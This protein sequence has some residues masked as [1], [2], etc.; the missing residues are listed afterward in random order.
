MDI[1]IPDNWLKEYLKTKATPKEIAKDL[2]LCGP[3]VERVNQTPYGP[4][5]SIEVTTNRIDTACVYGIAREASAILPRFGIKASLKPIT[6]SNFNLVQKVNYLNVD[7]DENLCPR[8]TAILIRNVKIGPSPKWMQDRLY[9]VGERPINNIVDIS[10]YLMHESGQPMHT[11]DYD[12]IGKTSSEGRK[13]AKMILR[14]SKKGE[15]VITLDNQTRVLPG[16]DIVIEDGA[17]RLIDLCGIMGGEL[18]AIDDK[19][20]N[21]LLFVQTYNPFYIR[22]TS[23]K[24]A[25]RTAAAVIFEKATDPELVLIGL[26]RGID[27]F[28][29]LTKGKPEK[30]ILDLYFK[31]YH[32]KYIKTNKKFIEERLGIPLSQKEI[33]KTLSSLGFEIK[34]KGENYEIKIPSYRANDVEIPEDIVEEV[35]RIY[36]YHNLKSELM[37]GGL[38]NIL[39]KS[40]FDFESKVK[41]IIK[42][43]GGVEIYTSS[44]V[45]ES[46]VNKDALKLK[47]PLGPES[48]YLRTSLMPS[49]I[50]AADENVGIK[51]SFHLFEMSNIYLPRTGDLPEEKMMLAGIF[52]KINY[53]EAKGVV[54]ALLEEL[55]IDGNF[56][57]E[58]ET[59]FLP[60]QRLAI[61]KD[62][63]VLG[64]IGNVEGDLT[65]YEF[66]VELLKN[67]VAPQ[68]YQKIPKFPAQIE[69]ITLELPIK[70]KVGEVLQSIK[71]INS[72]INK[73]ELT[74]IYKD[75][76]TF[77]IWYQHP[78]KTLTDKEVEEV[79]NKILQ[80]IK[81]KYGGILK[82]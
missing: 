64:Q 21:V 48:S 38:P 14:E 75:A 34:I 16:N 62:G 69:D 70:T 8:F 13:R 35:A 43:Y 57:P 66:N 77:R 40:P 80:T 37:A 56:I 15:K 49:L 23:M 12:K 54:E 41:R 78:T 67:N 55:N 26:Q 60:S 33:S 63:Q 30:K 17:G 50:K 73:A 4:V 19:T 11:F 74:D 59:G 10:N 3:S 29:D 61:K 51:D 6:L 71:S 81:A 27:L 65:Y 28:V 32:P 39:Y 45:P 72:L 76:Y 24:L 5:Y 20:K 36:G 46:F 79:R 44:L 68:K 42:G 53:R 47:N 52:F 7:I 22:R 31:P 82:A 18:S 2:S 9:A 1:L 58:D 25:H